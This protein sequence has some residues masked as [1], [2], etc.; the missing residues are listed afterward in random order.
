MT[1][2]AAPFFN[3]PLQLQGRLEVIEWHGEALEGRPLDS[4]PPL[5]GYPAN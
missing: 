3:A 1:Q 2:D 5:W 4:P